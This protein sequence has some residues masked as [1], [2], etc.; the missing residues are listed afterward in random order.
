MGFFTEELK[1]FANQFQT[2]ILDKFTKNYDIPWYLKPT[3]IKTISNFA[4]ENEI[5]PFCISPAVD[6]I[7]SAK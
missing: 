2:T 6:S 5:I 3:G 4:N 7:S 1:Y